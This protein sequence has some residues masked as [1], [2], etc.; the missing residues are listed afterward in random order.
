M[1]WWFFSVRFE[2]EGEG[3]GEGDYGAD[4][5]DIGGGDGLEDLGRTEFA[6]SLRFFSRAFSRWLP[7]AMGW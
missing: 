7:R 2:D 3:E 6:C 4:D 5:E 1:R